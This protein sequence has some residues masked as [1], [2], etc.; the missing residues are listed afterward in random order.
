MRIANRSVGLKILR[1]LHLLQ[2]GGGCRV[3]G[4]ELFRFLSGRIQ[5][6]AAF[7]NLPYR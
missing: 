1:D 3:V 5:N 4:I 7:A 6:N 2:H